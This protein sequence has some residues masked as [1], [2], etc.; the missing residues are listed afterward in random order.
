MSTLPQTGYRRIDNL[1]RS[2]AGVMHEYA[3]IASEEEKT[4][5]PFE[6]STPLD[7]FT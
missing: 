4:S 2:P 1:D 7:I 5:I 6:L 3:D